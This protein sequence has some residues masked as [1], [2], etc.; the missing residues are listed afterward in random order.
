MLAAE[1]VE[2]TS[3]LLDRRTTLKDALSIL[4]DRDVQAGV[5]VD[6]H[7]VYRGV[8]TVDQ[9]AAYMRDTA[10]P[11]EAADL[12]PATA[13]LVATASAGDG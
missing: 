1:L 11:S 4:L 7:G 13:D 12:P 8:I 10:R 6:R 9:I 3:P 2:T 5:V